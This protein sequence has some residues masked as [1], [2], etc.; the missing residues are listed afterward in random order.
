MLEQIVFYVLATGV[1]VSALLV[2]TRR[3]AVYSAVFLVACFC[4]IAGIYVLLNAQFLAAAQV[5]VYAGAIMVLFVFAIMLLR[6]DSPLACAETMSFQR[7]FGFAFAV[8]LLFQ[9]GHIVKKFVISAPMGDFPPEKVAAAGNIETVG[10][11]LFTK[12][13]YP[14]EVISILLLA[15]MIGAVVLA[16]RKL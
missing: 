7:I 12:Y 3:N 14:F 9:V 5:I 13:V 11:I 6:A 4:C 8:V 16:K 1:V 2:I 10:L 15:A